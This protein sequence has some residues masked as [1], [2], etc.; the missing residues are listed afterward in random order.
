MLWWL[1]DSLDSLAQVQSYG[2]IQGGDPGG[3][4][5]FPPLHVFCLYPTPMHACSLLRHPLLMYVNAYSIGATAR[6][7][8]GFGQGTGQIVLDNLGCTGSEPS[9]F[10]CTANAVGTH[11]CAHSED[12]GVTCTGM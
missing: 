10:N 8:A 6:C 2:Q 11:N 12:V 4:P 7:C 9:L 3:I 1:V 5:L